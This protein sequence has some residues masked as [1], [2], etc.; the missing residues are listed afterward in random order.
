MVEKIGWLLNV[1]VGSKLLFIVIYVI[2]VFFESYM[3]LILVSMFFFEEVL[4]IL[5]IYDNCCI[6]CVVNI[7]VNE[8]MFYWSIYF[9]DKWDKLY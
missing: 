1:I 9:V 5:K 3:W 8:G 6:F 7:V 2:E 4:I